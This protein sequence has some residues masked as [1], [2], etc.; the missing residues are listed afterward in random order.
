METLA[1][2]AIVGVAAAGLLVRLFGRKRSPPCGSGCGT[3]SGP[4]RP[5]ALVNIRRR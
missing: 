2:Y 5:Q 3:C 4:D 1:V